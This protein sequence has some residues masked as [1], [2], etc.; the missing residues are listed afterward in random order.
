MNRRRN[1]LHLPRA[2]V[3]KSRGQLAGHLLMHRARNAD[4]AD[5]GQTFQACGDIDAV[6]EQIALALN[7]VADADT[8]AIAHLP[9]GRIS[10]VAR[11]QAFLDIDG[12]AYC[13]DRA[14][15][16]R[17]NCI[18]RGIEDTAAGYRDAVV[19]G[20]STGRHSPQRLFFIIGDQPAVVG[21]VGYQNGGDLAPHGDGTPHK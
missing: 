8:D 20:G 16:F 17:K 10:E 5:L 18:T 13:F 21:D 7:H 12:A 15:E 2:D 14:G 11:A 9:A 3:D 6:A 1:I 19:N 4:A